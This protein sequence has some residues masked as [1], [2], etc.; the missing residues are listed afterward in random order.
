MWSRLSPVS[1]KQF[2]AWLPDPLRRRT[3]TCIREP[4]SSDC[5]SPFVWRFSPAS[6]SALR[7]QAEQE[8][9]LRRLRLVNWANG[10]NAARTPLPGFR[11]MSSA[12]AAAWRPR[13]P[14]ADFFSWLRISSR[15]PSW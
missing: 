15:N 7:W 10:R 9:R 8:A 13:T 14:A 1:V 12:T 6:G 5:T 11:L 3:V 2:I 4:G